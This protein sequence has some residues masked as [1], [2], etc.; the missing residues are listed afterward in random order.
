MKFSN[1]QQKN[2]VHY[3]GLAFIFF[4]EEGSYGGRAEFS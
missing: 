4:Q 3:N 2:L 1:Y